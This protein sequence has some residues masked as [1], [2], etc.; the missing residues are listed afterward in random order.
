MKAS[1]IMI[2]GSMAGDC[3]MLR[4]LARCE[5]RRLPEKTFERANAEADGVRP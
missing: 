1:Q 5:G 3:A 4:L 2:T